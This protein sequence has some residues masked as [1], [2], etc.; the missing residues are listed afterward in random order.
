MKLQ[1]RD[2]N[3]GDV[4]LKVPHYTD[5]E[6]E[7]LEMEKGTRVLPAPF[8]YEKKMYFE[9]LRKHEPGERYW[10][11][12]GFEVRDINGGIRSYDLDQVVIHPFVIKHKKDTEKMFKRAEKATKKRDRQLERKEK[13][14]AKLAG[15]RGR[16]SL[17]PEEKAQREQEKAVR[18]QASGGRRGRPKGTGT[19][20]K[21]YVPT[22]GKRGR[23]PLD[24]S[25]K[26]ARA[27]EAAARTI[28]S[29]GKRGRPK[30]A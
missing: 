14:V 11:K 2:F 21:P 7:L 17:S 22:G 9:F 26:E 12:G 23:R 5:I 6:P 10:P 28:K 16:P 13:A 8:F 20:T 15:K 30:R 18:A 4:V 24:P 3:V 29:G 25:I 19:A 1:E 27:R